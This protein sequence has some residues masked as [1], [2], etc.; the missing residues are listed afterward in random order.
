MAPKPKKE[1]KES[2]VL[3]HIYRPGKP[4][5]ELVPGYFSAAAQGMCMWYGD[6]GFK[7]VRILGRN[8]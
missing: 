8:K 3:M 1:I 2:M 6:E 4:V 5:P 7:L